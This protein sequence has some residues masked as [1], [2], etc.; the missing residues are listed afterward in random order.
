MLVYHYKMIVLFIKS[1][2]LKKKNKNIQTETDPIPALLLL[3]LLFDILTFVFI[4]LLTFRFIH[5]YETQMLLPI[6]C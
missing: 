5:F 2:Y 1:K 3:N 4:D 6:L